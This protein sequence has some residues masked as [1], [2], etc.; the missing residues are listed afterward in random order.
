MIDAETAKQIKVIDALDEVYKDFAYSI[1]QKSIETRDHFLNSFPVEVWRG[2]TDITEFLQIFNKTYLLLS[3][4]AN[5]KV[6]EKYNL[7][8]NKALPYKWNITIEDFFARID[9]VNSRNVI[10]IWKYEAFWLWFRYVDIQIGFYYRKEL[11]PQIAKLD[12]FKDIAN[13]K[14]LKALR[15]SNW[16]E[17][18]IANHLKR[19]AYN[20]KKEMN[21]F[22]QLIVESNKAI[23]DFARK[24]DPD[25]NFNKELRKI[26]NGRVEKELLSPIIRKSL[27]IPGYKPVDRYAE[28][29]DL[30]MFLLK[31]KEDKRYMLVDE[32]GFVDIEGLYKGNYRFYQKSKIKTILGLR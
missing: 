30:L 4:T 2:I 7:I 28:I 15:Y 12:Q 31:D 20:Q 26:I 29:F 14:T 17:D 3:F 32:K 24:I 8:L 10:H 25:I 9:E 11:L 1:E 16:Y 19:V 23:E 27:L 18:Q 6:F 5:E 21:D 13:G 22:D